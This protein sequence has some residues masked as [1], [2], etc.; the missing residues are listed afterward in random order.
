M[1]S[2]SAVIKSNVPTNFDDINP[3]KSKLKICDDQKLEYSNLVTEKE[4]YKWKNN[5]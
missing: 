4:F 1:R 3:Y 5:R 2:N